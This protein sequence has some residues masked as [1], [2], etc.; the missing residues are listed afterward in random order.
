MSD[1]GR[2]E[3]LPPARE[4]ARIRLLDVLR[5]DALVVNVKKAFRG[6][7]PFDAGQRAQEC[8]S[9][10]AGG[11]VPSIHL[12][13]ENERCSYIYEAHGENA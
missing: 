12:L 6:M 11:E 3:L 4:S 13:R 2:D 8:I 9:N 7:L 10:R 5:H 1:A